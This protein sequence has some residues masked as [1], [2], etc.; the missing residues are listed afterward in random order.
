MAIYGIRDG[1]LHLVSGLHENLLWDKDIL[2]NW[3]LSSGPFPRNWPFGPGKNVWQVSFNIETQ[4][5]IAILYSCWV[6]YLSISLFSGPFQEKWP[7]GHSDWPLCLVPVTGPLDTLWQLSFYTGMEYICGLSLDPM[8]PACMRTAK[9]WPIGPLAHWPLVKNV[10]NHW[11]VDF[12]ENGRFGQKID[13]NLKKVDFQ[14]NGW[15]G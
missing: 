13:Q 2:A 8:W 11:K 12:Q 7:F 15:F 1:N 3:P 5:I 14:E 9:Y 6:I 10:K 4:H